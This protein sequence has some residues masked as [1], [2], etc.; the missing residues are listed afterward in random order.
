MKTIQKGLI[1]A[2]CVG[3]VLFAGS[4]IA[5]GTSSVTVTGKVTATC[6]F[7][8]GP[9]SIPFA[10]LD[11]TTAVDITKSTGV[12]YQ[13]T[14]GTP[15]SSIKVNTAASPTT[16]SIVNGA[17]SLP[18]ELSWTTPATPG[19]GFGAAPVINMTLSGKIK[20]ADLNTA[21]AGN[22]SGNWNIDLLP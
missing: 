16:V 22:Y 11:P 8:G 1:A 10:T 14:N 2:A 9:F 5:G 6:A 3:S 4:A 17:N 20:A 13:C 15:A 19:S 18:V 7:F 12:T 21:V